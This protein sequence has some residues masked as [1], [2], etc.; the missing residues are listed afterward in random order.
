LGA[1]RCGRQQWATY[2][3]YTNGPGLWLSRD[4]LS[5]ENL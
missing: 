4:S 1:P 2:W 3:T 5:P